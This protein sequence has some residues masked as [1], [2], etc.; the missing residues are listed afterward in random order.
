M[1]EVMAPEVIFGDRERLEQMGIR[2]REEAGPGAHAITERISAEE[3]AVLTGV[4]ST[5]GRLPDSYA[6]VEAGWVTFWRENC[7]ERV[8]RVD[9]LAKMR[10]LRKERVARIRQL[11][12]SGLSKMQIARQLGLSPSTV[13]F[14]LGAA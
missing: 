8:G 4:W 3:T 11:H 10:P 7:F 2:M 14:D 9:A 5:L 1:D 12:A 13:T 6:T